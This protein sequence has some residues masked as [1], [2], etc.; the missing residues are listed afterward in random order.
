M[1]DSHTPKAS[2]E[3]Q[4]EKKEDEKRDKKK[5]K[6]DGK[7]DAAEDEV[8]EFEELPRITF[9]IMPEWK[10]PALR[11]GIENKT[12]TSDTVEGNTVCPPTKGHV[13]KVER[14]IDDY[15]WS[16]PGCQTHSKT[17]CSTNAA[18]S[19]FWGVRRLTTQSLQ[20][21][22]LQQDFTPA[23]CRKAQ[24]NCSFQYMKMTN[25][26]VGV[27]NGQAV[28]NT[29]VVDVPF[30]TNHVAVEEGEE[31]LLEK[32]EEQQQPKPKTAPKPKN[33]R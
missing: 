33:K 17:G 29:K 8:L 12:N 16:E 28:N 2:D 13:C 5:R 22:K 11:P 31:L 3:K 18:I 1:S 24:F 15:R 9:H 30:L 6:V 4:G 26:C 27:M 10:L 19:P 20:S 14:S 32:P 21:L 23:T 7:K 25:V